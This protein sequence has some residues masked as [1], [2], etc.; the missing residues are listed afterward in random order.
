[1]QVIDNF[2]PEYQFKQL[3]SVIL[4][5]EFPWYFNDCAVKRGDDRYQ[6]T[7]RIFNLTKGKISSSYYSLFDIAQQKLGV[8]RLDRI[9]L[10]LNPKTFFHRKNGFHTDQRSEFEG[11]PQHQKTAV[12]SLNTNNG[13][14]EFKK[15]G[16]VKSVANRLVTFDS[17]LIHQGVTCTDEK[18]RVVI[19]FN[20]E[21]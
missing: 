17:G 7:H 3:Q 8:S 21:V 6:F 11:V 15:G 13:W 2:L 10:N 16:K 1:M 12:F 14:T 9:K 4:S 19:N 5:V 20:Y 18:I